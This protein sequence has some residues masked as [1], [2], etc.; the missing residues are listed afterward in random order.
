MKYAINLGASI[1]DS[2][3]GHIRKRNSG[4]GSGTAQDK[5][6]HVL[7]TNIYWYCAAC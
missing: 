4:S 5:V 6:W 7:Y 2:K 3:D 1:H